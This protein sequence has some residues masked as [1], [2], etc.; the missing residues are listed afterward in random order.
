M[1]ANTK[2]GFLSVLICFAL[3]ANE[4]KGQNKINVIFKPF[5]VSLDDSSKLVLK[6]KL[7][8]LICG[9]IT[10]NSS[11][12]YIFFRQPN[13]KAYTYPDIN[14]QTKKTDRVYI[15]EYQRLLDSAGVKF[16]L[17]GELYIANQKFNIV[18]RGT[19]FNDKFI[20]YTSGFRDFS[21]LQIYID[22]ACESINYQVK[23]ILSEKQLKT[24]LIKPFVKAYPKAKREPAQDDYY[25]KDFPSRYL[26]VNLKAPVTQK[27]PDGAFTVFPYNDS[28]KKYSPEIIVTGN[29]KYYDNDSC[30]V[31]PTIIL[32]KSDSSGSWSL[33][34]QSLKGHISDKN[35]LLSNT[36]EETQSIINALVDSANYQTIK[37]FIENPNHPQADYEIAFANADSSKNYALAYWYASEL[38]IKYSKLNNKGDFFKG[39]LSY[40]E[41]KFTEA[42]GFLNKYLIDNPRD[43]EAKYYLGYSY[44]KNGYYNAALLA[45]KDIESD[46]YQFQDLLFGIAL[47]NYSAGKTAEAVEYFNKQMKADSTRLKPD[48]TR[49]RLT[50]LYL[51]ICYENLNEW[52]SGLQIAKKLYLSD[53]LN[54]VNR[55]YLSNYY[56]DFAEYEMEKFQYKISGDYY[57]RSYDLHKRSFSLLGEIKAA[58]YLENS[59]PIV[60]HLIADGISSEI[61]SPGDIYYTVSTIYDQSLDSLKSYIP[62]NIHKAINYRILYTQFTHD[63]LDFFQYLGGKYFRLNKLD[64]A[65][66]YYK[67]AVKADESSMNYLNLAEFQ[68]ISLDVDSALKTLDVLGKK[69]NNLSK[70]GIDIDMREIQS[71][72][73]FYDIQGKIIKNASFE[74]EQAALESITKNYDSDH[75]LFVSWTFKTYYNWLKNDKTLNEDLRNKLMARLCLISS[76]SNDN[77]PCVN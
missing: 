27:Y 67:R 23:Q 12:L 60:S 32:P 16:F 71:L 34:L 11:L 5:Q 29:M 13:G 74:Q 36:L 28:I 68:I 38:S 64:S 2:I 72:Y 33:M 17:Q 43:H 49:T 48:T 22:N 4:S 31:T 7:P 24:V 21:Q 52:N 9:G 25:D 35:V 77:L 66:Y 54:K 62:S 26:A 56:A 44:L 20:Y 65:Q 19:N 18:I 1:R 14:Y 53:S 69:M 15:S 10:A 58:T 51:I 59:D 55:A 63:S 42:I 8:S 40:Q 70:G 75:R 47:C 39:K 37:S 50:C 30:S 41:K 73:Y 76:V 45:L 6:D 61:F 3:F 46:R 57:K